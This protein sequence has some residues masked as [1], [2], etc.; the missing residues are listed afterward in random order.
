MKIFKRDREYYVV[1]VEGIVNVSS[2]TKVIICDNSDNSDW[3][4]HHEVTF[5]ET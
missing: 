4:Y 1:N 5:Y 2:Q 3:R